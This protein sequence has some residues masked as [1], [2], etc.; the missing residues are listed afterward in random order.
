MD[1]TGLMRFVNL[2]AEMYWRFM[3]ALDPLADDP[4]ALPDDTELLADLAAITYK[5]TA[6][7]I[8]MES[9]DEI[10]KRL[11]RS[12]DKGDAVVMANISTPKRRLLVGGPLLPAGVVVQGQSWEAQRLKELE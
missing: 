1:R 10:K 4:I 9:K 6:R 3:E 5:I 12:T 8:Q 11:M 7:G 2:R